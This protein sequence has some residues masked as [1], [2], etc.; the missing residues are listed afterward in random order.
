MCYHTTKPSVLLSLGIKRRLEG[1]CRFLPEGKRL[2]SDD[3]VPE[4][5]LTQDDKLTLLSGGWLS[6]KHMHA[7]QTLLHIHYPRCYG[8]QDTL[9][10]QASGFKR[11]DPG[12]HDAIQI[13]YIA[14]RRH[15]VTTH[16]KSTEVLIYDSNY[17]GSISLELLDQLG[18]IYMTDTT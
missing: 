15:W 14:C 13:H 6:D 3:W 9:L 4:L 10:S 16:S 18:D 8:F 11:I 5:G 12:D 2:C 1:H 17:P 7:A